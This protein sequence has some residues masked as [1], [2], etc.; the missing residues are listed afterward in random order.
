MSALASAPPPPG[1]WSW[2]GRDLVGLQGVPREAVVELL[3]AARQIPEELTAAGPFEGAL[4]G[5]TVGV[6][7]F[8]ASTR[9]RVSFELAAKRL[10]A[11]V[12]DAGGAASS[13]SKGETLTDTALTLEAMGIR[14]LIVRCV[15]AGGPQVIANAVA[16]PV[17]SAGDGRHEHPTQGLL[18]AYTI[19]EAFDRLDGFDLSGLRVALVGDLA[20]SRVARSDAAV[21]R[22]LGAEVVLAGPPNLCPR[23]L[24][25]LGGAVTHDLDEIIGEIDAVQMLR[26]Q[27]ERGSAIGSGRDYRASYALTTERAARLKPGAVVLHPGPMNRGLEIDGEVADGPRSRVLRQVT[28]GVRVRTAV[29]AKL[30]G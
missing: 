1:G 22:A 24:E 20:G 5:R 8:E 15:N 28:N 4:A 13:V 23:S 11:R 25:A 29:L 3:G 26:V 14:A 18:D 12:V 16:G 19:A 6:A 7:F 30:V 17:I 9:T 10:G 27:F 2:Q 21:L